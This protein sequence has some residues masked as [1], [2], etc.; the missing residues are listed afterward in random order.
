MNPKTRERINFEEYVNANSDDL[1]A[2]WME[3]GADDE[4]D[5]VYEDWLEKKYEDWLINLKGNNMDDDIEKLRNQTM[6]VARNITNYFSALAYFKKINNL[7]NLTD[8]FEV[9]TSLSDKHGRICRHLKHV[10]RNDPKDNWPDELIESFQGYLAYFGM[11][12]DKYDIQP[13]Q[14]EK[15][16]VDELMKSVEQHSNKEE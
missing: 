13:S 11:I 10:E 15:S 7:N 16:I 5:S 6:S 2:E 12:I 4:L 14:L 8:M 9:C 1:W 3:S